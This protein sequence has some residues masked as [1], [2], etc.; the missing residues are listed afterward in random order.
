MNYNY[1]EDKTKLKLIEV[2]FLLFAFLA[3]FY[4]LV[5]FHIIDLYLIQL[6]NKIQN[7]FQ[8]NLNIVLYFH[9]INGEEY[10]FLVEDF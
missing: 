6:L 4:P 1:Y 2:L 8:M 5:L 7:L 9:G 10:L 3:I